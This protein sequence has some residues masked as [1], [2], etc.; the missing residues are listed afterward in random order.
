MISRSCSAWQSESLH[1]N[2]LDDAGSHL[3]PNGRSATAKHPQRTTTSPFATV[4]KT[5]ARTRERGTPARAA[6]ALLSWNATSHADRH[7]HAC[8]SAPAMQ[9]CGGAD[10]TAPY[11]VS[12]ELLSSK[13]KSSSLAGIARTAGPGQRQPWRTPAPIQTTRAILIVTSGAR[14]DPHE[15]SVANAI[16]RSVA[17][18]RLNGSSGA[19]TGELCQRASAQ[20]HVSPP[21][22][23]PAAASGWSR[24]RDWCDRTYVDDH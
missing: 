11:T 17:A 6:T 20:L 8:P 24:D 4:A 14:R 22:P 13:H 3:L 5:P 18:R 9:H 12:H 23:C 15:R 2:V 10:L 19:R 7:G 16:T 1:V 21:M